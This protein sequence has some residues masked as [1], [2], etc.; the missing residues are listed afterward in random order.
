MDL[1]V[2]GR[3]E[4]QGER[5]RWLGYLLRVHRR[6]NELHGSQMASAISLTAFITLFPL[7]LVAIAVLGFVSAAD[8]DVPARIVDNL[9]LT[10]RAAET[11]TDA[12]HTAER[13]RRVASVVGVLGLL[14]TGLRFGGALAYA[15]NAAWQVQGRG[16]RDRL[17]ALG[18]LVGL[19][20]LLAVS[21]AAT[22]AIEWL[23][24]A[25]APLLV[26]AGV[27]LNIAVF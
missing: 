2:M 22:T 11:V 24:I 12:V 9:G 26:V 20:L 17:Y 8:S 16:L 19:G 10:G 4:R 7:L 27:L 6:A 15:Y 25:V 18:W 1:D 5:W 23:T 3:L 13:S 21:F 14:W